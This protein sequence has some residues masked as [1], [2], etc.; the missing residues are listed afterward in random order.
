MVICQGHICWPENKTIQI[1]TILKSDMG[2]FQLP[3]TIDGVNP[4]AIE[5]VGLLKAAMK[6][7]VTDIVP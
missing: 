6:S 4:N 7:I 2:S 1:N 3:S 5:I